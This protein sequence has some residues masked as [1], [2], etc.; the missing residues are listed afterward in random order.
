VC[1]KHRQGIKNNEE[2]NL[3]PKGKSGAHD[4]LSAQEREGWAIVEEVPEHQKAP[5]ACEVILL[6]KFLEI[7]SE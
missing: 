7:D 3:H 6:S 5:P 4:I 2:S 1:G